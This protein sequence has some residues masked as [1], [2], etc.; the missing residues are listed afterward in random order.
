MSP[1][2]LRPGCSTIPYP[3]PG[4]GRSGRSLRNNWLNPPEWTRQ[5]V[6]TFP[7]S[8]DGPWA[9]F[10]TEPDS[11]GIGTVRYPRSV[12]RD[13]QA[14]KELARRTLTNLYN[15]MPGWLGLAHRK[16]D[17]AVSA[18]YG[19][20]ATLTDE[21]L[22]GRLLELNL[23]RAVEVGEA[24]VLPAPSADEGEREPEAD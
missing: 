4:G 21:E 17:E 13:D 8:V 5:D 12:A 16:L 19:W 7:G 20:P 6:L 22:L 2:T 1:A 24:A 10:V 11:R 14:A 9:R 23:R 15:Q 3:S 18:A